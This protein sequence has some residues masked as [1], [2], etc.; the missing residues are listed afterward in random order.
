MVGCI[1]IGRLDSRRHNHCPP[2]ALSPPLLVS[3]S[4][5]HSPRHSG[6]SLQMLS[7]VVRAT[8][9][10]RVSEHDGA[11]VAIH[12][13]GHVLQITLPTR[14]RQ[15]VVVLHRPAQRLSDDLVQREAGT[16]HEDVISFV[17]QHRDGQLQCP[18]AARCDDDVVL[19][20]LA[21]GEGDSGRDG[22]AGG[23]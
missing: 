23:K 11:R 17:D 16:R 22:L 3:C 4:L 15:Q 18:R 1:F 6:H 2:S 20:D 21:V 14:L 10:G 7:R 12:Q 13:T 19:R 9:V 8:R 5:R